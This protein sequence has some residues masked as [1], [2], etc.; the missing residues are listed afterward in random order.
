MK[1]HCMDGEVGQLK[2]DSKVIQ[3]GTQNLKRMWSAIQFL[4]SS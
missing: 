1:A 2:A 4:Q 3:K